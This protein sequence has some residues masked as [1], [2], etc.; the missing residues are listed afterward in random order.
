[1]HTY[2]KTNNTAF[3]SISCFVLYL[4]QNNQRNYIFSILL[5]VCTKP[6]AAEAIVGEVKGLL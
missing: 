4:T 5:P 1:M 2:K 6:M 3:I